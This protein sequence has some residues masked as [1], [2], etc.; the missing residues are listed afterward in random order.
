MKISSRGQRTTPKIPRTQVFPSTNLKS[1]DEKEVSE[2]FFLI[3]K[4][5]RQGLSDRNY[6][7]I[8]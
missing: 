7:I 1:K 2:N 8:D 6:Q 3:S 4:I 5:F